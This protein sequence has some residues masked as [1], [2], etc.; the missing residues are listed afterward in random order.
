MA[1]Q[2]PELTG[3]ALWRV[4]AEAWPDGTFGGAR[5]LRPPPTVRPSTEPGRWT[6]REQMAHRRDLAAA[7]AD[8]EWHPD[9]SEPA[10]PST[11]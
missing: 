11:A 9:L 4:L 1:I 5:T 6:R 2:Q 7:I 10:P 8:W 3:P